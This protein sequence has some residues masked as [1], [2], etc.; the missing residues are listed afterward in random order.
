MLKHKISIFVIT[1][2]L[3]YDFLTLNVFKNLLFFKI[4]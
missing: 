4:H 3:H 1:K 2:I